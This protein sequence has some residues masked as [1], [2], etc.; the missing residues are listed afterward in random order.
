MEA[1]KQIAH[2][3]I[4]MSDGVRLAAR[5]WLPKE[6]PAE[7]LPAILEY[8]PYRKNDATMERDAQIHPYFAAHG[9][10]SV[11]VDLRGSGDSEGL[12]LD[13]YLVQEQDDALEVLQ[14]LAVQPWCS[15]RVGMIGKSWGGFNGLQIAARRPSQLHAVISVCSTDDRYADDV[16]YIGG[17]VLASDMLSWASTML[18]ANARPPDPAIVGDRW[19][20]MWF[21]RLEETP[22]YIETWL[23]HQR[24]DAFW[25]H[26]SVCEDF[27]AIACPVYM[28]GGWNDAYTSAIPRFLESYQGPRKGL[29]G[30][31]AHVYPQDAI[32]GPSIGFL[33]EC[34]RFWDHWLKDRDTG[35]MDEPMLRV[36]MQEPVEPRPFYEERPGRWVAEPIWPPI[37]PQTLRLQL[38]VDGLT[39]LAEEVVLRDVRSDERSG[40]DA[41]SWIGWG[42]DTDWATDQR[43]EDSLAMTFDSAP[44]ESDLEVL[45]FVDVRLRIA[46]DRP[47]AFVCVRLC[48]V[49]DE[50]RS[51]LITRG[52]LN[53][54]HRNGHLEPAVMTPG[55]FEDIDVRMKV[56]GHRFGAGHRL[57]IAITPTYWPWVWPSPTPV[58][59]TVEGGAAS[60][61]TLP[62]RSERPEDA[63][64]TPFEEPAVAP[65]PDVKRLPAATPTRTITTDVGSRRTTIVNDFDFFG[66]RRLPDG[67]E[68]SEQ[69]QD[70]FAITQGEPLSAEATSEWEMRVGRGNWQTR[71]R[72]YS[73][74]VSTTSAFVV[75][76]TVHAYEG[77]QRVFTSTRTVEVPRDH[78]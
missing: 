21:E 43:G 13:E 3:W 6:D 66:C 18:A 54:T 50:G 78:V 11:R 14:W 64:L 63:K 76:N 42:R 71:V 31:W 24:R 27:S 1:T 39:P 5:I 55:R 67:L 48:E 68:Y 45:G 77:S 59:L 25:Q 15:G 58:R 16:H 30:P 29:I 73:T 69:A 10:A 51:T 61:I 7:P 56:I 2:V 4:P 23:E 46:S 53:L 75:S 38:G 32:P 52:I 36:W 9:Y 70:R 34:L 44:L 12:M 62:V 41:G 19:R 33:Q 26:G 22:P 72:T 35:V 20:E 65:P 8:I 49:D 17:C 28:V 47:S 40:I 74:M 57:R 37:D 60:W